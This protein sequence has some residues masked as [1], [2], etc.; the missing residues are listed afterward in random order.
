MNIQITFTAR[1]ARAAVPA[2]STGIYRERFKVDI[3]ISDHR[4]TGEQRFTW[5]TVTVSGDLCEKVKALAVGDYVFVEGGL[6]LTPYEKN[7]RQVMGVNVNA[8]YVIRVTEPRL[9][10]IKGAINAAH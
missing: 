8:R 1:V 4:T 3:P 2:K 7:G 10:L 9:P 5:A 6:R